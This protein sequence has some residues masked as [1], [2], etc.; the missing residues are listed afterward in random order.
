MNE[1]RPSI[2]W[3]H[4]Q[5]LEPLRG[6]TRRLY[7]FE[8]IYVI[9]GEMSVVFLDEPAPVALAYRAGDL[10]LLRPNE[11]HRIDIPRDTG[12]RLLGIHF[13]FHDEFEPTADTYMVVNEELVRPELFCSP[14]AGQTFARRYE[15][16]PADF[17]R[18]MEVACKAFTS[19]KAG[20]ELACR[21]AMLL[22]IASLMRMAPEP[23]REMSVAY[24]HSLHELMAD[25]ER[26]LE[27]P[28]PNARM[29][30]RLSVSEDHFIRLFKEHYASTPRQY[31]QRLR[32]QEAK[33]CLRETDMKAE[34]IGKRIGCDSLHRFSHLFK[35]QEG[36]SPREYRK[37]SRLV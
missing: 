1:I 29:A 27:Q 28:W 34:Q 3:A 35:Q 19:A 6:M 37:R 14:P 33:R 23:K 13:D 26:S 36:I 22:V 4:N 17:V 25:V 5:E 7:D 24:R 32:H 20:Q 18:Y 31:V 12:A 15:S 16:V 2:H 8:L 21:G 11:W 30:A 9:S 10:L